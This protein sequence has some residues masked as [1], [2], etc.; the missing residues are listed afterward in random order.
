MYQLPT[1]CPESVFTK[2]DY[3]LTQDLSSIISSKESLVLPSTVPAGAA[4]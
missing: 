1:L 2:D 3:G 4:L